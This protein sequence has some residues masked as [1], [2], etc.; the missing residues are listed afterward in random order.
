MAS[1]FAAGSRPPGEQHCVYLDTDGDGFVSPVDVLIIINYSNQRSRVQLPLVSANGEGESGIRT[2]IA[3]AAS[4]HYMLPRSISFKGTLQTLEAFQ[5][6]IAFQSQR[7]L[8]FRT[9]IYQNLLDA[10]AVH[11]VANR[12]DRI[13]PRARKRRHKKYPNLMQCRQAAK[14]NVLKGLM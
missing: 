4:K 5:P 7:D 9:S 1:S 2:I 13:E 12:P 3:Q 6:L 11:R 8:S 14:V 10:I